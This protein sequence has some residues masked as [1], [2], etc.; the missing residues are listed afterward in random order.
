M[1]RGADVHHAVDHD[2]RVLECSGSQVVFRHRPIDRLPGPC[3]LEIADVRG[4]MSDAVEYLVWA[5]SPPQCGHSMIWSR[6]CA[7]PW[8]PRQTA[9]SVTMASTRVFFTSASLIA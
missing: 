2:R 6:P 5:A 3:E 4:V 8:E 1:E 9:P 7:P